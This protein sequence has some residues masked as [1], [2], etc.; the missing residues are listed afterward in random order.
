MNILV[1][2]I[3]TYGNNPVPTTDPLFS[4]AADKRVFLKMKK[5]M[6]IPSASSSGDYGIGVYKFTAKKA[7]GTLPANYNTA[8]A[9]TDFPIF[10]LADAYLMRAEALF[11]TTGAAS[12]LADINKIRER[13]Y[14]NTSGNVTAG[15]ITAQFLL[16]ERCREF[17]YEAQRRTDLIRFGKFTDGGYN[18]QWK[19]GTY[20]GANTDSDLNLFPIPG[21]EVSANPNIKQNP[22]Y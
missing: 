15:Q 4:Q 18:W 17:Y 14:G 20:A 11:N 6:N 1:D 3:K 19:G 7:D 9:C 21:D 8:F 5:T 10:R 13:A 22:G 2:T 12:A 16:D